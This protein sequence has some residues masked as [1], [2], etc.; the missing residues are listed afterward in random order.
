MEREDR[1]RDVVIK[2]ACASGGG[3]NTRSNINIFL[4]HFFLCE[5]VT[6]VLPTYDVLKRLSW[7]IVL[8]SRSEHTKA[9]EKFRYH[10]SRF[11]RKNLEYCNIFESDWYD[12][13]SSGGG[14]WGGVGNVNLSTFFHAHHCSS[15]SS[16][17]HRGFAFYS[18]LFSSSKRCRR[19]IW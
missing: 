7:F 12:T 10:V 13:S 18:R 4:I 15:F 19:A 16:S 2:R 11:R 1:C 9:Q 17:R 3:R 5:A 14:W 6:F 8:F